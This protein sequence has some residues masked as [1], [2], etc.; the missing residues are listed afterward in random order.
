MA[1]WRTFKFTAAQDMDGIKDAN[2]AGT[3][4]L[5]MVEDTVGALLESADTGE[6]GVL[7]YHAEKILVPKL[8]NS[9]FAVGMRVYYDRVAR[10]VT[11]W[12][13]SADLWIGIATEA[14]AAADEFVE[15]DLC[16]NKAEVENNL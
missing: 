1:D 14:A 2:A 10:T 16:G 13:D 3:S 5:Y 12:A 4:Y 8:A 9:V 7:V 11:P 15:I 6:E